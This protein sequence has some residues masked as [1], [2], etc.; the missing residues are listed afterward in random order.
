[1]ASRRTQPSTSRSWQKQVVCRFFANGVC[2]QAENCPYSHDLSLS[3]KGTLPCK[4]FA[5]GT[6]AYGDKCRFSHGDPKVPKPRAAPKQ[7]TQAMNKLSLNPEASPWKPSSSSDWSAAPEFVP[8]QSTSKSVDPSSETKDDSEKAPPKSWA[9]LVNPVA[10]AEMTIEEA[11][12][13]LCPFSIM[14]VCRYGENC[15]Y[16][17]GLLCDMCQQPVLHP[18]HEEQRRVHKFTCMK[19]HE[20]EMEQ[21]FAVAKSKDRTCGICMEV[22]V[23][24]PKSEARFGIMPNCN[25][26]FC[27]AC[28]RKWRQAKQFENKIIRAC[29]ECRQT[30]DYICP[31][32]HWLDT[33]EEKEKLFEEY[34]SQMLKK[35]CKYY[36]RGKGE[37][38]FGNKCFYRHCAD[39]GTEVDVGPPQKHYRQNVDGD[40]ETVERILLYDF[41]EERDGHLLLPLEIFDV[42][43][44]LSESDGSEWD[45]W[46]T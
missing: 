44:F 42:L 19:Q 25:H 15:A 24:K 4:Y 13:Q 12:S 14:D 26:C 2:R 37:C 46:E 38:P 7:L 10:M 17:H 28:L 35:E 33:P 43:D 9:H 11:E 21:A 3:N 18:D 39:D 23:D 30:S 36:N 5:T 40:S 45:E 29:P 8:K 22:V 41:L 32:K 27:L 34:K 16:V 6:C 31:S 20:A 1:M